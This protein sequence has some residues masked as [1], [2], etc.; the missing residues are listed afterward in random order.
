MLD[1]LLH[2]MLCTQTLLTFNRSFTAEDLRSVDV[3][4]FEAKGVADPPPVEVQPQHG[5]PRILAWRYT[6][7][8]LCVGG[9]VGNQRYC[10]RHACK[11]GSIPCGMLLFIYLFHL[12]VYIC[13]AI[14]LVLM[15]G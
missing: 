8:R 3:E 9:C 7:E 1:F 10:R 6:K 13:P 12:F 4:R 15:C 2:D 14:E 11:L 5:R